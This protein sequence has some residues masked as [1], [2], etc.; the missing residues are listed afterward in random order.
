MLVD[1][2]DRAWRSFH[3]QPKAVLRFLEFS[4]VNTRADI[5]EKVAV[6]GKAWRSTVQDPPVFTVAS[7]QPVFHREGL[8]GVKGV[9]IHFHTTVQVVGVNMVRPAV[10]KLL[11]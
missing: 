2:D 4:D 8:P 9:D 7:L 6:G 5:T 3:D 10:P 1:Q 11:L